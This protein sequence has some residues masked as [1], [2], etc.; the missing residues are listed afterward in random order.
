VRKLLAALLAGS[1]ALSAGEILPRAWLA[2]QWLAGPRDTDAMA[3]Y[4]LAQLAP[5][6]YAAEVESALAAGDTDLA[7]SLLDLA[8]GQGVAL[9]PPLVGRVEA[10]SQTDMLKSASDMWDGFLSGDAPSDAALA[11]AVAADM[12]GYTDVRDL[13]D[14]GSAYV[15]GQPVDQVTVAFA[16]TGLVLT[17]ATVM[18]L[19]AAA[20]AKAGLS[21]VKMARRMGH[22]SPGLTA[23]LG[24]MARNAVDG[25][26]LADLGR[27][28]RSLDFT[29]MRAAAARVVRQDTVTALRTLG[30]DVTTI[31]RNGGYRGALTALGKADD[32]AGVGRM[33]RLSEKYGRGFRAAVLFIGT[34]A[35][36]LA[37]VLLSV[38]GWLL[39][40]LVWA[41]GVLFLGLRVLWWVAKKFRPAS[42]VTTG[43]L[44]AP[45]TPRGY[46]AKE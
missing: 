27:M 19:G 5:R 26:A 7:V 44:S 29:G 25:D 28:A 4:R 40:A 8:A 42:P 41:G 17:A 30:D 45:R 46:F 31:G 18:T 21:T 24:R 1:L 15:A 23:D 32:A 43:G 14:Q 3:A 11:G 20:P 35:L 13:Y 36:T 12:V 38:T 2:A 10:A 37:S 39:G 9:P 22:L 6:D 33:A 34:S 16:A